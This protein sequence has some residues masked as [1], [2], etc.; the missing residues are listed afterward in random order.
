MTCIFTA[1][2]PCAAQTI[3]NPGAS[4]DVNWT[5]IAPEREEELKIAIEPV[6]T[7]D[8]SR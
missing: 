2:S 3:C 1:F 6:Y 7:L 8:P 5:A 4:K